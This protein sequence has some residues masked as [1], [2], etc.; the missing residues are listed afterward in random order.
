MRKVL[1]I[2]SEERIRLRYRQADRDPIAAGRDYVG[3]KAVRGCKRAEGV[4]SDGG[5]LNVGFYLEPEPT[6]DENRTAHYGKEGYIICRQPLA[7][8]GAP[9]CRYR[10]EVVLQTVDVVRRQCNAES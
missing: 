3:L 6:L 2:C 10:H 8:I 9:R 7:E 1:E 4:Y 5:R